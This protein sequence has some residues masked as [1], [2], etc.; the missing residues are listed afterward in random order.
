[1]LVTLTLL[2]LQ[3]VID[4]WG[5]LLYHTVLA[6]IELLDSTRERL[7]WRR[8]SRGSASRGGFER[9]SPL[10]RTPRPHHLCAEI[11]DVMVYDNTWNQGTRL[12][13]ME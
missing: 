8:L 10:S 2:R 13:Q 12:K 1:M 3:I 4:Q 9:G 7:Y 5:N 11:F 6:V